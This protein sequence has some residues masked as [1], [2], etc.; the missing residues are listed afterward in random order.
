MTGRK[1]ATFDKKHLDA[2]E[3]NSQSDKNHRYYYDS[4][5]VITFLQ[6]KYKKGIRILVISKFYF[7]T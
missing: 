2:E 5:C 3:Q 1:P 6:C 7:V 4:H